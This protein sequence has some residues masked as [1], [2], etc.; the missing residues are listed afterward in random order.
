MPVDRKRLAGANIKLAKSFWSVDGLNS[1]TTYTMFGFHWLLVGYPLWSA[2]RE[3][4]DHATNQMNFLTQISIQIAPVMQSYE[5]RGWPEVL[6]VFSCSDKPCVR[7]W[8]GDTTRSCSK[9]IRQWMDCDLNALFAQYRL[10]SAVDLV[11][12]TKGFGEPP[13]AY[14]SSCLSILPYSE[15]CSLALSLSE[16]AGNGLQRI[17]IKGTRYWWLSAAIRQASSNGAWDFFFSGWEKDYDLITSKPFT[18]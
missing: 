1:R 2:Q 10:A 9:P 7:V 6:P 5:S 13:L 16:N 4:K 3:F 8:L 11:G 17:V 18:K 14:F 15:R 12:L